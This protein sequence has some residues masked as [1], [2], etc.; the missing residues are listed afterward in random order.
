MRNR[1]TYFV[2]KNDGSNKH[3]CVSA[4]A[5][6]FL[7]KKWIKNPEDEHGITKY[8]ENGV[9]RGRKCRLLF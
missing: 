2:E 4:S 7:S 5:F 3:L 1:Y 8:Y 6:K 9:E